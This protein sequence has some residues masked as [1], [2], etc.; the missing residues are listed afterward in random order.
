MSRSDSYQWRIKEFACKQ[1]YLESFDTTQDISGLAKVDNKEQLL[2]LQEQLIK[3]IWEL[4]EL[5]CTDIQKITLKMRWINGMTQQ[6]IADIRGVAQN[7]IQK[8]LSGQVHNNGRYTYK[9][10]YG[11]IRESLIKD[12]IGSK[13]LQQIK[14]IREQ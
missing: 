11:K 7:T 6:E 13:I 2:E 12:E 8:T 4:V 10:A 14:E 9:G 5:Q 3:R 1:S